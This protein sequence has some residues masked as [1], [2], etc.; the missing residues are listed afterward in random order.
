MENS[1]RSY[2]RDKYD[3]VIQSII[4]CHSD[5]IDI[6]FGNKNYLNSGISDLLK[7]RKAFAKIYMNENLKTTQKE[8]ILQLYSMCNNSLIGVLGLY[9]L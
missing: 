6:F 4:C 1:V 5:D 7:Q 3:N 8:E 2:D 9:T